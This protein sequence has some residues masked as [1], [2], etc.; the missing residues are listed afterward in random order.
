[1][2]GAGPART[3][4]GVPSSSPDRRTSIPLDRTAGASTSPCRPSSRLGFWSDDIGF[5][6][7]SL[8]IALCF[9]LPWACACPAA[10]SDSSPDRQVRLARPHTRPG[11]GS[12][13]TSIDRATDTN[14]VP[15]SSSSSTPH[16]AS[17]IRTS[18]I[19]NPDGA[20]AGFDNGPTTG[21]GPSSWRSLDRATS[22]W[23]SW[24]MAA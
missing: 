21:K 4:T 18:Q 22:V 12:A 23:S 6:F 17:L 20:A 1:M 10:R 11:R 9:P 24:K 2:I 19:T 15:A 8:T 5:S 7:G 16:R 14:F 3:S 13:S